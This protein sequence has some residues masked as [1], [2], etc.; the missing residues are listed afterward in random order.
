M[1]NAPVLQRGA[2]GQNV[3]ILQGLLIA[4]APDLTGDCTTFV[5]G[6]FGPRTEKALAGWKARTSLSH[7]AVADGPTWAW[8]CGV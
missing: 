8:L 4:H 6:D 5:D 7:D 3:R 1:A 2:R